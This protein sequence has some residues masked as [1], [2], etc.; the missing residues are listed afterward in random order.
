LPTG[1]F[2]LVVRDATSGAER[3]LASYRL[4]F[5]TSA[6]QK[7]AATASDGAVIDAWFVPPADLDPS[8]T[9]PFC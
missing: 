8:R 1:P 5:A 9:Y 7:L 4:P 2:R 3:E 6:P